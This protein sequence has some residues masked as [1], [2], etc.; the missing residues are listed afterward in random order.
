MSIPGALAFSIYMA[1]F[2]AHG[3]SN[4]FAS[5]GPI[6]LIFL[7][8]PPSERMKPENFYVAGIIPCPKEPASFQSN[9]LSIPLIKELKELWQGYHF[10]PPQQV[11]QD[12]LFVLPSSQP[13]W[14]WLPCASLLHLFLIQETTFV[15]FALFTRLKLKKLVPNFTTH[16]HTKI[17]NQEFQN[18]FEYPH[19]RDKQF[20]LSMECD[21]QFRK[22]FHIGMHP[23]W[24][25]LT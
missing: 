16:A 11:L 22:T 3:K 6:I 4:W 19:H 13:L 7:N 8:L 21:I 14:M 10:H 23:E 17:I 2:N 15:I 20:S 5:S 9:Y 25:I 12:P 1:W 18:G 24:L